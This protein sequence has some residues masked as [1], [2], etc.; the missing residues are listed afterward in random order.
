VCVARPVERVGALVEPE[1]VLEVGRPTA[2]ET[3]TG[4][5]YADGTP[6]TCNQGSRCQATEAAADH[7]DISGWS[8][9]AMVPIEVHLR[10]TTSPPRM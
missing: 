10:S 6:G 8:R 2:A 5:V 4:L 9:G 3:A 7:V 1:T